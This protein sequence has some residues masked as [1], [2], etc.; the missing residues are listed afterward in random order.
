MDILHEEYSQKKEDR[1]ELQAKYEKIE[2]QLARAEVL[3][4]SLEDEQVW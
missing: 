2:A 3:M 4:K 1:D